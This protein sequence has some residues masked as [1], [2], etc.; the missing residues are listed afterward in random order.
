MNMN[1]IKFM[2]MFL[3]I[4]IFSVLFLSQAKPCQA[5]DKLNVVTTTTNLS[6]IVKAVGGKYVETSSIASG[7]EDPHFIAA[8]PSYMMK[9]KK[10]DLWIRIGLELEIGYEGLILEGSRNP[11]IQLGAP[12]HL[13]VSDG[14]IRLEV[15]TGKVDRSMGDVHPLGNPH[16]WLDPYNGRIIAKNICNRLK[17]LD[18]EHA[19]DYDSNL[20]SFH[21]KLDGAMFGSKLTEAVGGEKLWELLLNGQLNKFVQEKT[22]SLDGWLGKMKPFEKANI[23][24]YHRSWSYFANRFGLNVV[25]ELEPKPGIPPGP[26]HVLEVME[27]VKAQKVKVILTEPFYSR[28]DAE[29]VAK[30]TGARVAVAA[31][32]V[33]DQVKDYIEMMDNIVTKLTVALSQEVSQ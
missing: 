20:A 11:R 28:E 4:G 3:F 29:G 16:Y 33:N 12:G 6:S 21:L 8:K 14:I 22:L 15:P 18:P 17:Q 2:L 9:A 1:S 23:V 32:A 26:K 7:D 19:A 30:K 13:D 27:T 10:A 24:T 25:E 5:M 31:V